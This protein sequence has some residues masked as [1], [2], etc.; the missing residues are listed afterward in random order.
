MWNCISF[1]VERR[2]VPKAYW[3]THTVVLSRTKDRGCEGQTQSCGLGNTGRKQNKTNNNKKRDNM[4]IGWL[5][6]KNKSLEF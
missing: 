2:T 3:V 6:A 1:K 4:K 5:E